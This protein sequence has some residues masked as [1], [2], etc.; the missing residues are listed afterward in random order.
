[1]G[2]LHNHPL[3]SSSFPTPNLPLSSQPNARLPFHT[4]LFWIL[5]DA[6]HPVLA[7][8]FVQEGD[9]EEGRWMGRLDV[10]LVLAVW[11]GEVGGERVERFGSGGVRW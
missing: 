10:V 11:R 9:G 6:G 8:G 5:R 4:H 3:P 7:G 1:M 2:S